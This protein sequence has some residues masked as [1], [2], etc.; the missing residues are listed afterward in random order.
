MSRNATRFLA[1]GLLLAGG[2]LVFRAN[3]AQAAADTATIASKVVAAAG[4][5]GLCRCLAQLLRRK[6]PCLPAVASGSAGLFQHTEGVISARSGY[7]GGDRASAN[8][9]W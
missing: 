6:S 2:G 4:P 8:Y 7:A 9:T 5:Q 3:R 1:I